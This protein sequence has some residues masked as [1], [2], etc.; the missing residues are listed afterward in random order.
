MDC[1]ALLGDRTVR[2]RETD[3][4]QTEAESIREGKGRTSTVTLRLRSTHAPST[5]HRQ[6]CAPIGSGPSADA[7]HE[8]HLPLSGVCSV[9]RNQLS[10]GS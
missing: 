5:K 8:V 10:S 6:V 2:D 4:M 3:E 7:I 1:L 9:L